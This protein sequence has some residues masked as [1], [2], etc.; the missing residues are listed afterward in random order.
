MELDMTDS[1]TPAPRRRSLGDAVLAAL[2]PERTPR[3]AAQ[4]QQAVANLTAVAS[5]RPPSVVQAA[6]D[7]RATAMMRA[8]APLVAEL[9]RTEQ[10]FA[11]A[12]WVHEAV[13]RAVG[14]P[15]L[16]RVAGWTS[17][18]TEELLAGGSAAQAMLRSAP[19]AIEHYL[20][21]EHAAAS[22]VASSALTTAAE[23]ALSALRVPR[24]VVPDL[25]SSSWPRLPAVQEQLADVLQAW[26]REWGPGPEY[27]QSRARRALV[28][29]HAACR[30]LERGDLEPLRRFLRT[31]L[32]L[33][34]TDPVVD[35]A[36][37]VLLDPQWDAPWATE[38]SLTGERSLTALRD[39]VRGMAS[40]DRPLWERQAAGHKVA[41]LG[42][43]VPGLSTGGL[44]RADILPDRSEPADLAGGL[45][46]ERL[47]AVWTAMN[48][49]E[50]AVTFF[51]SEGATTWADAAVAAGYPP[52]VGEAVRRR[53]RRLVVEVDRRRAARGPR[54]GRGLRGE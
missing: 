19:R 54:S 16:S 40:R 12:Q 24:L 8:A 13:Q 32:G 48:A 30:A 28:A 4:A 34:P 36:V 9:A 42:E 41:L 5:M 1:T 33:T 31:W 22:W 11:G 2:P 53:R 20:A 14:V 45:E 46:D 25:V 18:V 3:L 35:A 50:R 6:L 38:E 51:R 29:A 17:P 47:R 37:E 44:T 21:A 10:M 15:D 7:A 49:Q 43:P 52:H 27:T 26:R 39:R 23:A